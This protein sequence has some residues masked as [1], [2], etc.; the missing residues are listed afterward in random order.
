[1]KDLSQYQDRPSKYM[2]NHVIELL[3]ANYA[4]DNL[5]LEEFEE[6]MEIAEHT[7]SKLELT[8]LVRD[9]PETMPSKKM[10]SPSVAYEKSLPVNTGEVGNSDVLISIF[11]GSERKGV[12]KPPK[13]VISLNVFG[14]SDIDFREALLNP[15]VTKVRVLC[16][17]GGTDIIVP[18]GVNVKTK[19]IGLFGGFSSK[20]MD[21]DENSP[22]II[23]EG[24]AMFGG[25]D[26][27]IKEP[28]KRLQ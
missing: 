25:V 2:R 17:F 4:E 13:Q 26:V 18:P 11:G 3:K 24:I 5:E 14:G 16:L 1:M 10:T 21:Y 22:T 12:W 8:A 7:D 27:K 15:G 28:K 6:R 9:L 23:V 20:T 19:G